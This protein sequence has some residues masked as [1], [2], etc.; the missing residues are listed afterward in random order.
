MTGAGICPGDLLVVGRSFPGAD[1][2]QGHGEIALQ[3]LQCL[4]AD[5]GVSGREGVQHRPQLA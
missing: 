3:V 1:G 5:A 4:A 2:S